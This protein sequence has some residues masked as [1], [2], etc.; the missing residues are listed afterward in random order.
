MSE[1]KRGAF[2]RYLLDYD[3]RPNSAKV[4]NRLRRLG[5]RLRVRIHHRELLRKYDIV[6]GHFFTNKYSFL[7][8]NVDFLTFMREPV[9]RLLS[10]YYYFKHVASKNPVTVQKNPDIVL[11]AQGRMDLVEFARADARTCIYER[12]T[13]G[14]ALDAFRL[15]GITERYAESINV[16]NSIYGTAIEPKHERR[17]NYTQYASGYE[18]LLPELRIAN[19]ENTRIYEAA[20]KLFEQH[21]R[22]S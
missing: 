3:D 15:I 7:Y 19:R 2:G 18:H 22:Q 13:S 5:S 8:P 10:H 14:I 12:F 9:S 20:L 11:V 21:L 1:I 4:R 17:T 6:H 16:L